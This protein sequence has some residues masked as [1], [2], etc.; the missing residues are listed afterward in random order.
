MDSHRDQTPDHRS[1]VKSAAPSENSSLA[2][3]GGRMEYINDCCDHKGVLQ[4]TIQYRSPV[5]LRGGGLFLEAAVQQRFRII[6][7]ANGLV[8]VLKIQGRIVQN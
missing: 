5:R 6:L 8:I 2:E 4:D 1:P 7:G 3:D